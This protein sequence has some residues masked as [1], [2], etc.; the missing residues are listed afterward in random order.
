MSA[1]LLLGSDSDNGVPYPAQQPEPD[2]V[3]FAGCLV[4]KGQ[5]YLVADVKTNR[6]FEI[7]GAAVKP[8]AGRQVQAIAAVVM[9]GE[10]SNFATLVVSVDKFDTVGAKCVVAAAG[11]ATGLSV[12]A[13]V[14]IVAAAAA[15]TIGGLAAAG[16]L[17]SKK[18]H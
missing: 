6:V 17:S 12:K 18:G 3:Q 15:G 9:H 1:G 4:R 7:R 11:A 13:I 2:F 5:A 10:T 8:Y 16:K 14:V